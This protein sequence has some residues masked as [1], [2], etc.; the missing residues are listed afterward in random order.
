[1]Y[2]SND[3]SHI[4]YNCIS[5][6]FKTCGVLAKQDSS[7]RVGVLAKTALFVYSREPLHPKSVDKRVVRGTKYFTPH[8]IAFEKK[9]PAHVTIDSKKIATFRI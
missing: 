3:K 2:Y 8:R 4:K 5:G 6:Q 1:L 9:L 7:K